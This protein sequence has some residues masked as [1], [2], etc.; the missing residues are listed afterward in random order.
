MGLEERERSI[1]DFERSWWKTPGPKESA[2]RDRFGLSTTRYYQILNDLL[3]DPHALDYDQLVVRRL[4]R[5]R[6]RR[7]RAR[8]EG[9]PVSNPIP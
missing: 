4:R 6:D 3:D 2:I 5:L 8:F 7:R 9:S 1:L